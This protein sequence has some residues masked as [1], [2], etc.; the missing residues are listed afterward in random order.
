MIK[1]HYQYLLTIVLFVLLLFI[2]LLFIYY[3][4]WHIILFY[5]YFMLGSAMSYFNLLKRNVLTGNLFYFNK[6]ICKNIN[7]KI[8]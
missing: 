2:I 6:I 4:Y 7:K 5:F 8:K 1:S 3:L